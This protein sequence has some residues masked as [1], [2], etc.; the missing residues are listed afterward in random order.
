[1]T[2]FGGSTVPGYPP[3]DKY[4]VTKLEKVWTQ[5]YTHFCYDQP[6]GVILRKTNLSSKTPKSWNQTG[7]KKNLS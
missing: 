1:M 6:R 3:G 7:F 4:G 2:N 5:R